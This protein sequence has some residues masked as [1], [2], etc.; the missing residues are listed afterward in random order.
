MP[1]ET[2]KIIRN[3]EA[4]KDQRRVKRITLTSV[5]ILALNATPVT[6]IPAF[7]QSVIVVESITAR[8]NFNSIAYTG[9]NAVEFRYTNASGAK[10]SADMAAALLNSASTAYA[11][12]A[13]VVTALTPVINSPIVVTVP[14]ADPGAGNSTLELFIRFRTVTF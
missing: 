11:S 3:E 2:L 4:K 6:L 9:A 12:V 14:T 13:G 5:Q 1:E 10:V 8:L 7:L